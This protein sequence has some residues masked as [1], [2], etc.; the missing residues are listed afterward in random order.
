MN[1]HARTLLYL[2]RFWPRWTAPNANRYSLLLEA[3]SPDWEPIDWRLMVEAR[4]VFEGNYAELLADV[5]DRC[6]LCGNDRWSAKHHIVPLEYGGINADNNMIALCHVCHA[7]IHPW[8]TVPLA[9][10]R[11]IHMRSNGKLEL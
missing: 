4:A 6:Q 8:M 5:G 1:H 11:H 9:K 3:A 7:A 10:N 2:R